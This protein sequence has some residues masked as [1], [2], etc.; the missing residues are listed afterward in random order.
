MREFIFF[1]NLRNKFFSPDHSSAHIERFLS[2]TDSSESQLIPDEDNINM[3][4]TNPT[5]SA[6]YF[7][8]LRRQAF[9]FEKRK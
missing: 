4:V 3:R 9:K 5:T 7:H 6:Q 2:L 1:N 8:L